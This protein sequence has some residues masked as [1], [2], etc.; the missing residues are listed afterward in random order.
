MCKK[1][2]IADIFCS[3]ESFKM[4]HGLCHWVRC[5]IFSDLLRHLF[6]HSVQSAPAVGDS[7]NL[8][9][10]AV[11]AYNGC[12]DSTFSGACDD[13]FRPKH[14]FSI[15]HAALARNETKTSCNKYDLFIVHLVAE[16]F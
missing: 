2:R 9:V 1:T 3:D 7:V 14:W 4:I 16:Y 10:K 12:K 8:L 5:E 11:L 13:L 6:S 15:Q